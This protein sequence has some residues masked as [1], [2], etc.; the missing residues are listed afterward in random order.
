MSIE[1]QGHFFAIYIPG[2]VCFVRYYAKLSGGR[3]QDHWSSGF[4]FSGLKYVY[5]L[6]N[7]IV[8]DLRFDMENAAREWIYELDW[9]FRLEDPPYYKLLINGYNISGGGN[10][11]D[12]ARYRIEHN[13]CIDIQK[14]VESLRKQQKRR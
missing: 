6:T 11:N 14:I 9:G 2:F 1:G 7:G 5:T 12:K 8:S 4:K 13:V 10:S 3:L